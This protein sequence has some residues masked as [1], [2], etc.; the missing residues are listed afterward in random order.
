MTCVYLL[1]RVCRGCHPN[2]S[3]PLLFG[4]DV[5]GLDKQWQCSHCRVLDVPGGINHAV[6]LYPEIRRVAAFKSHQTSSA[7]VDKPHCK[8]TDKFKLKKKS[9]GKTNSKET[10][11][12][13]LMLECRQTDRRSHK[14]FLILLLAHT[15][16]TSSW[17][18]EVFL[19]AGT[20]GKSWRENKNLPTKSE[21]L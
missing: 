2:L 15:L 12:K 21:H 10:G 6:G 5:A 16:F 4:V 13:W 9:P 17:A 14:G 18:P 11:W 3:H 1:S 8:E 19:K 7:T 20:V